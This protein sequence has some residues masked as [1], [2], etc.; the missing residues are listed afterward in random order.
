MLWF[1][2]LAWSAP[3]LS[4]DAAGGATWLLGGNGE[5]YTVGA[6]QR[7]GMEIGVSRRHAVRLS[8]E[9]SHHRLADA[10]G[11]FLDLA[12]PA[13]AAVGGRD[14]Q[15]LEFGAKLG[16]GPA[17]RG[18]RAPLLPYTHFGVGIAATDTRLEVASFSGRVPLQSRAVLP[19]VD[20]GFGLVGPVRPWAS[21]APEVRV[22]GLLA[23]DLGEVDGRS[24]WG[25]EVRLVPSLS[26][27]V[28]F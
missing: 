11:Y 15:V 20:L 9:H 26:A 4:A 19:L 25:V 24:N 27:Q 5:A 6:T 21:L 12:V 22:Q 14:Y 8:W 10:S 18:E 3:T 1:A 13:T 17:P 7:L 16:I 28:H 23:E 2:A